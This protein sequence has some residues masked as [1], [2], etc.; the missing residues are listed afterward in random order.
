ME[1]KAIKIII[2]IQ[3]TSNCSLT[4][5]TV[6]RELCTEYQN[7]VENLHKL[8]GDKNAYRFGVRGGDDGAKDKV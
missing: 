4:P 6:Y 5:Y 7:N 8:E 2:D 1:Q 3:N